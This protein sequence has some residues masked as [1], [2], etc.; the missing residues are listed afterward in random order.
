M[1]SPLHDLRIEATLELLLHNRARRVIDLGCGRGDLLKR[2]AA[3]EQFEKIVGIDTSIE[4]LSAAQRDLPAEEI[5]KGRL[6]LMYES[7]T[8]GDPGRARFDAAV[9]LETIEHTHP[10]RLSRVERFV[11]RQLHPM[12]VLITTPNQEYNSLLHIGERQYRHPEHE[13]EWTRAKFEAWSRGV[14][15]RNGYIAQF[16]SIGDA[17]PVLGSATQM[18][19][20]HLAAAGT[21][22]SAS[23]NE[24]RR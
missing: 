3:C 4:A 20:F 1:S 12:L 5:L 21:H 18:G 13:F 10:R 15:A 14:A 7:F 2:L 23:C 6:T 9:M 24:S 8:E 19:I 17:D 11:F 22:S 16:A